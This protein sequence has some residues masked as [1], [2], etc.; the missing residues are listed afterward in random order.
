MTIALGPVAITIDSSVSSEKELRGVFP[1]RWQWA[2]QGEQVD[3][4][5]LLGSISPASSLIAHEQIEAQR[6]RDL[7]R[8]IAL[9]QRMRPIMAMSSG[10]D[11]PVLRRA[12]RTGRRFVTVRCEGWGIISIACDAEL[13]RA[14]LD[15]VPVIADGHHRRTAFMEV[16]RGD[17][18]LNALPAIVMPTRFYRINHATKSDP[19]NIPTPARVESMARRGLLLNAKSTRFLPRIEDFPLF[20]HLAVTE[21]CPAR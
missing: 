20:A 18:R 6:V 13:D 3:A 12:L 11:E 2:H 5:G 19:E 14:S 4:V 15:Q 9:E 10:M 17:G 16:G 1:V 7:Q 8:C 21:H